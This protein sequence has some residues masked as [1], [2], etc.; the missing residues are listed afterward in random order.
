[1]AEK[2]A[3]MEEERA[4]REAQRKQKKKKKSQRQN[5]QIEVVVVENGKSAEKEVSDFEAEFDDEKQAEKC[6][7][8]KDVQKE[9]FPDSSCDEFKDFNEFE[10]LDIDADID[11]QTKSK[12]IMEGG[13]KKVLQENKDKKAG[14]VDIDPPD[15]E[16]V[17]E[18]I[19]L[20]NAENVGGN[21]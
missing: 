3:K 10:V 2:L 11:D 17:N 21:E 18:D 19:Y 16:K 7:E 4:E 6:E 15:D 1:M 12:N 20:S 5:D 14:D 13:D 9:Q 8:L